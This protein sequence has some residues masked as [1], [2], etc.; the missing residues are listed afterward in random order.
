MMVD[1]EPKHHKKK[2]QGD[3]STRAHT[4][5]RPHVQGV[6]LNRTFSHPLPFHFFFKKNRHE[7]STHTHTHT[8]AHGC[9]HEEICAGCVLFNK[10]SRQWDWMWEEGTG[11][12]GR[13]RS[14]L[15]HLFGASLHIETGS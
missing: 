6:T 14:L 3:T 11:G 5:A 13:G 8:R 9:L 12:V 15:P 4:Q 10:K 1:M 7:K 2:P